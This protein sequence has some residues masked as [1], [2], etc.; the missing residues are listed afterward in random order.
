MDLIHTQPKSFNN[1][2]ASGREVQTDKNT[3][4]VHC[5][6]CVHMIELVVI[7]NSAILLM[8]VISHVF[9]SG[10]PNMHTRSSTQGSI[11]E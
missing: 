5:H 8:F 1:E 9:R 11:Q 7:T 10:R 4:E 6:V 3:F 2:H